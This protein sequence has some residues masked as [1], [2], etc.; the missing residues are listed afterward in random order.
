MNKTPERG[1]GRHWLEIFIDI[2]RVLFARTGYCRGAA[3]ADGRLLLVGAHPGIALLAHLAAARR[4]LPN[5]QK[6]MRDEKQ[7]HD[8]EKLS[9]LVA[10]AKAV[11]DQKKVIRA[12]IYKS[13]VTSYKLP[14][15]SHKSELMKASIE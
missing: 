6:T 3:G 1:P 13:K 12:T 2:F 8:E 5:A 4:E 7:S 11:C 10:D 15:T 14:A 9:K